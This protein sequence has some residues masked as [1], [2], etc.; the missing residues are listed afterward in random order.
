MGRILFVGILPNKRRT[1]SLC[2]VTGTMV[3][4]VAGLL[5]AFAVHTAGAAY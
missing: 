1:L 2:L 3:L 4:V 5:A